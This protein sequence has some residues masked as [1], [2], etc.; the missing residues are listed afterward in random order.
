MNKGLLIT[1]AVIAFLAAGVMFYL[2]NDSSNLDELLD[3]WFY[4]IPLGVLALIG[5]FKSKKK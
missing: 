4:P 3:F 1:I 5:I 2:G